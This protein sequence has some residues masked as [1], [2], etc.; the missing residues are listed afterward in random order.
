MR[1][2]AILVA[3][4]GTARAEPETTVHY[5]EYTLPADA[6]GLALYAGGALSPHP[7]GHRTTTSSTLMTVGVAS[8]L[9]ATPIIHTVRGHWKRGLGS[10]GLRVGVAMMSSL[11]GF[12]LTRCDPSQQL[13]CKFNGLDP[14]LGVGLALSSIIDVA[15]LTEEKVAPTWTPQVT[16]RPGGLVIGLGKAF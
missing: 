15:A 8:S 6:V 13:G 14:G 12:E 4:A 16:A 1:S 3:L 10:L 11:I 2:L 5:Y 9:L 7:D